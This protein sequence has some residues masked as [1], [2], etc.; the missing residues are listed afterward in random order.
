MPYLKLFHG[1]ERPDE[2]LNDWGELGPIFGPFPYFHTTYD[3]DIKFDD[4]AGHRLKVVGDLVYYDGMFYGDRSIYD[5]P[6]SEEDALRHVL[7]EP[8]KA[9]VPE[10]FALC[11][12]MEPGHVHCGVPDVIAHFENG[13]FPPRSKVKRCDQ[14]ERYLSDDA[15][16]VVSQEWGLIPKAETQLYDV[17]CYVTVCVEFHDIAATTPKAAAR[18]AAALFDWDEHQGEAEFADEMNEFVVDQQHSPLFDSCQRFN[19]AFEEID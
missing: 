17:R 8:A 18:I 7:F 13:R 12:C 2:Q 4:T 3:C 10:K 9:E 11:A 5:G 6:I 19:A 1:R 16:K 15:S 14:C